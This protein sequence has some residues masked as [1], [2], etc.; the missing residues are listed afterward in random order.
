[1][2]SK[3]ARILLPLCII[4]LFVLFFVVPS[5]MQQQRLIPRKE[6]FGNPSKTQLK[7]APNG[8]K[9]A[10]LAPDDNDVLNVWVASIGEPEEAEQVTKDP[11]RGIRR[12]LWHYDS[13]HILYLQDVDGNE[14]WHLFQTDMLTGETQDLTPFD[15]I[16]AGVLAYQPDRPSEMLVQINLRDPRYFDVYR[17][18]L[19]DGSLVMDT[20]N[21][22]DVES[23]VADN[24]LQVRGANVNLE[25]GGVEIRYRDTPDSDWRRAIAWGPEE[26]HGGAVGFTP[27]NKSLLV[28]SSIDANTSR[29]LVVDPDTGS[30]TVLVAD[31]K[32]DLGG[33]LQ[34][35][36]SHEILA[37][38]VQREQLEWIPVDS[39]IS[40]DLELVKKAVGPHFAVL[41]ASLDDRYWTVARIEDQNPPSYYLVDRKQGK[42]RN[43]FNALPELEDYTLAQSKPISFETRD[44]QLLHGYL[45]MPLGKEDTQR[46]AV[47]R[48]HGG[49][50]A[51][52]VWGFSPEVQWLANRG[53]AVLQVNFRGSSGYGKHL[54]NLGDKEW[55]A[56]MHD[57]VLDAKQWLVD[58]GISRAD[59]IAVY[60][61]SYGGYETLAALSFT[62]E[63]FCCGVAVVGPSNLVTLLESFPPY[64]TPHKSIFNRRVGNLETERELL[65]ERSPLNQAE[66]IQRSLLIA[67][68]ANDPRVTKRESD[69][70]VAAMRENNLPVTYIVFEDEGH[71]FARPENR[72]RFYAAVEKFLAENLGG[73]QQEPEPDE[74]WEDYLSD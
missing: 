72:L 54:L 57:D 14:N 38:S 55:G 74:A 53:Y 71:G 8:Q 28:E 25:D 10:F 67:Q 42:A 48:V 51:R 58:E 44:G 39:K 11:K 64:W 26:V 22:G 60:G 30:Y 24:A 65:E 50:W 59:R 4:G 31:P 15:G 46:P 6:L 18:N 47:I 70:I 17:L 32:Y 61:G 69:Q 33:I 66:Q 3:F 34:H 1:M 29:L 36:L 2:L 43:L 12:Y 27:D 13:N 63:E 19:D 9:L 45:T 16:H 37:V 41:S 73:Y 49:P 23:W 7:V 40:N 21:P 62:P 5:F 20:E 56:K 68:G 35:P 52:D